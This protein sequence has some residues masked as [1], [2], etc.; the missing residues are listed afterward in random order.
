MS[1]AKQEVLSLLRTL[2]DDCSLEDIQYHLY[3]FAKIKK[4]AASAQA[5][6]TLTHQEV[7]RRLSKWLT[8]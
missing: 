7:K 1:A 6:G 8:E 4:S 2:P 3:I 5:E